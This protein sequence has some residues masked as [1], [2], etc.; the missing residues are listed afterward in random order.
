MASIHTAA[1]T[2]G[3]LTRIGETLGHFVVALATARGR[4]IEAER[5]HAMSDEKLAELGIKREDI[6]HHVFRDSYYL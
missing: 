2:S 5:L 6:V 3:L 1:P 4:A